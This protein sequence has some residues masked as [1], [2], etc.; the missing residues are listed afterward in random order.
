MDSAKSVS[1]QKPLSTGDLACKDRRGSY[2]IVGRN[3]NVLNKSGHRISL[4]E[5][6]QAIKQHPALVD[7]VAVARH[8]KIKGQCIAVF[9]T[10]LTCATKID[11]LKLELQNIVAKFM[12]RYAIPTEIHAVVELP[13]THN[14]KIA[15]G[16]LTALA[17]RVDLFKPIDT[18]MIR[19]TS[20]LYDLER[21]FLI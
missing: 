8:H 15:R 18:S 4:A 10:T 11:K 13:R 21:N 2:Y 17:S 7:V 16:Y 19:N 14:G 12:G 1:P 3:D 20:I 9:V 5:V 6:K